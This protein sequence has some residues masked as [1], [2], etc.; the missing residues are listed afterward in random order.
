MYGFFPLFIHHYSSFIS[1]NFK[2]IK[3]KVFFVEQNQ[4][5]DSKTKK[6]K[7]QTFFISCAWF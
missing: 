7:I 4:M 3:K 2:N 1:Q 6:L 5:K